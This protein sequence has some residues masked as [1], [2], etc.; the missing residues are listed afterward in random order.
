MI[1]TGARTRCFYGIACDGR[2]GGAAIGAH[3]LGNDLGNDLGNKLEKHAMHPQCLRILMHTV[4][5]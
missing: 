5:H 4:F 1:A 2:C 3:C